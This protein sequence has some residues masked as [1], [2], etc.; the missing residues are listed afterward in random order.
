[1][2]TLLLM[3]HA[4]SA[5]DTGDTDHERP[6]TGRGRKAAAAMGRWLSHYGQAPTTVLCSTALRARDTA[7]R[8]A[9]A[10]AWTAAFRLMPA[11]Y[12]ATAEELLRVVAASDEEDGTLMLVGHEPGMSSLTRLLS[13]ARVRFPTGAAA[14]IDLEIGRWSQIEPGAGE[15]VWLLPPRLLTDTED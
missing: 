3:R 1:M 6:L 11:I 7:E 10:G 9:R 12:E 14:R 5:W 4:K 13:G 8:A 2:R 15:L